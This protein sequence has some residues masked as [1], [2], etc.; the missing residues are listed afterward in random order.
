MTRAFSA[1]LFVR[2]RSNQEAIGKMSDRV[3]ASLAGI[4]VVRSFALEDAELAA[5]ERSNAEYLE[6]SLGLARLRGSMGPLMG[7]ISA[8]GILVVFW[9]GGHL[10][11]TQQMTKGDFVS[12]W[13]ALLRLT[14]PMLA[15]GFVAAIVQRGRAGY[16][17]LRTIFE[18]T[19]E[20]VSGSL[21][22]PAQ[23]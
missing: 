20:V 9:Y 22:R 14:W 3:L 10:V 1:R 15:L 11:L 18:A 2:N 23:V 17:R 8:V 7:A 13:M 19:P 12:F 21:P 4:R 16:A 5:F 6:Q